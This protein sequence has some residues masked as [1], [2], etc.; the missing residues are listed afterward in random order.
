KYFKY[1]TLGMVGVFSSMLNVFLP[2]TNTF[3]LCRFFLAWLIPQL[4]QKSRR[5]PGQGID[6]NTVGT[7]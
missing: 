6:S 2:F 5:F 3:L 1:I 4:L 7:Q